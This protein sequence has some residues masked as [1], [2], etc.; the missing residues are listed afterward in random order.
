VRSGAGRYKK[1][2][3]KIKRADIK[4]KAACEKEKKREMIKKFGLF[5]SLKIY[6][7]KSETVRKIKRGRKNLK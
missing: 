7:N 5:L 4:N 1:Y 6:Q 3:K 2:A